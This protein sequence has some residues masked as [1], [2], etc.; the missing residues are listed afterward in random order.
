MD[1]R[2]EQDHRPQFSAELLDLLAL[3]DMRDCRL[4]PTGS[5][6]TYYATLADGTQREC[7]V[8]YKPQRGEAPLWDFPDGTLYLREYAAY[9]L[10]EAL[11]WSF[12]P[13]TVTRD[14]IHGIGSV[15]L[16][17][18][19]DPRA[20]YFTLRDSYQDEM[21]RLCAFDA[22][23]NNADRKASHCLL[24]TDGRIW[25]IDHGITFHSQPK[26]RTVIWG[27]AGDPVPQGLLEDLRRLLEGFEEPGGL[28]EQ[29]GALLR[30]DEVEAFRHRVEVLLE[31]PLFPVPGPRRAVPWPW[32]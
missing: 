26:L 19:A 23:S 21:L 22:I 9:L 2:S 6:Y 30:D 10:S 3:G 4:A 17:V 32:L 25:A 1:S 31:R 20:N 13:P 18:E 8:V 11:G 29:F 7:L 16:Y 12:V 15:Q 28:Y 24:D 27:F 5:N 14:G